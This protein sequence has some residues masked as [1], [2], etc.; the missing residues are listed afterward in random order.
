MTTWERKRAMKSLIFLIEKRNK[1]IKAKA[2]ATG[3]T[4]QSYITREEATSPTAATEAVLITG[5]IEAKQK[6]DV[7]T[8]D[9]SNTFV[10]TQIP[11]Q[12]DKIIMKIRGLLVDILL[13]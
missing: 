12:N 2:C 4:Q 13:E 6:R 9:V 10:Q 1:T 3:S 8:F 5:V 11:K 7:S